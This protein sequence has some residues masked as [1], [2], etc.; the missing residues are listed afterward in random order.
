MSVRPEWPYL[1]E[2]T[3]FS[4]AE[5]NCPDFFTWSNDVLLIFIQFKK[6]C[7]LILST[8]LVKFD[9]CVAH[10]IANWDPHRQT[11]GRVALD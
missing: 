3:P 4:S 6:C 10:V 7:K 8:V 5:S 11:R 9:Q 1:V 2:N